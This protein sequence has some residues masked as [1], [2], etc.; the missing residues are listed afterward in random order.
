MHLT[1]LEIIYLVGTSLFTIAAVLM[2]IAYVWKI[3]RIEQF[4]FIS[5]RRKR[6]RRGGITG[7]DG[8]GTGKMKLE[9]LKLRWQRFFWV[10]MCLFVGIIF[11]IMLYASLFFGQGKL[12]KITGAIVIWS[13]WIFLA[14]GALF[15]TSCAGIVADLTLRQTYFATVFGVL[16]MIFLFVATLSQTLSTRSIWVVGSLVTA[17]FTTFFLLFPINGVYRIKI[18]TP[19]EERNLDGGSKMRRRIRRIMGRK[20]TIFI[21]VLAAAYFFNILIWVLSKSNEFV[22]IFGDLLENI[23]YLILD[24]FLVCPFVFGILNS[25]FYSVK[26]VMPRNLYDM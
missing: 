4:L 19:A 13:R 8:G 14:A 16:T 22:P 7:E 18:Y 1:N 24:I 5:L 11:M 2:L 17:F 26:R 6:I 3:Y 20:R 21:V 12:V 25:L 23:G 9:K 10:F 15:L